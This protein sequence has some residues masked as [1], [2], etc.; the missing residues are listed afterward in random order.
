MEPHTPPSI[1]PPPT[2]P[3]LSPATP[4]SDEKGS[5]LKPLDEGDGPTSENPSPD[6]RKN[7]Q[8]KEPPSQT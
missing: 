7:S 6:L 4:S 5:R 2:L 8:K 3:L 1:L